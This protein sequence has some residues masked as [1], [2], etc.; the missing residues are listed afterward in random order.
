MSLMPAVGRL[1]V[2]TPSLDDPNFRGTVILL[3]RVTEKEG[4]V[5]VILNRPTGLSVGKALPEVAD[6][7]SEAIWIGGPVAAKAGFLI[8]PLPEYGVETEE[9]LSGLYMPADCR[10][11]QKILEEVPPDPEGEV[12]RVC[13]GYAGWSPGQLEEEMESG[14]WRVLAA[15]VPAFFDKDPAELWR[16]FLVR[17]ILA[18]DT[19]NGLM[20]LN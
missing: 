3:C 10:E 16:E 19:S 5:G 13:V 1:L 12:L 20:R 14:S 4:A 9:V 17:A 11:I 15:P 7:R 8:H 18:P 2:A 6:E